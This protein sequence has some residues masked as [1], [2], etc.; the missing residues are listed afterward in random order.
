MREWGVRCS[1]ELHSSF[2][3]VLQCAFCTFLCIYLFIICWYFLQAVCFRQAR[4]PNEL[5]TGSNDRTVKI[6]NADEASYIETL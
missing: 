6:W 2:T 3:S 1:E 5:F 4:N